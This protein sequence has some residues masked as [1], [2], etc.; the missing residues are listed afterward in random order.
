MK[1]LLNE[2]TKTH[3]PKIITTLSILLVFFIGTFALQN[4]HILTPQINIAGDSTS[5][6]SEEKSNEIITEAEVGDDNKINILITGMGGGSHDAPNLTD[7]I[8]LASIHKLYKTISLLSIPRDLWVGYDETNTGKINEI[9]R[10]EAKKNESPAEGMQALEKKVSEITGESIDYYA[11]IDFNGFT[12]VVDA[13]EGVE[14]TLEKQFVDYSFPDGEGGHRT[15]VLRK[16]TWTLD[17]ETAL[18]YARSRHST[19]DFDRSLRQ[20]QILSAI[21]TKVSQTSF[22][23]SPKKIK[24]FYDIFKEYVFTDVELSDILELSYLAKEIKDYEVIPHNINDSCFYGSNTC[25]AGGFLYVPEREYFDGRSVLL[26]NGSDI[27]DLSDYS[28]I[29]SYM[30]LVFN[31]PLFYSEKIQVNIF[32]ATGI[33]NLA[34]AYTNEAIK[35]G[36]SLPSKNSIGNTKKPYEKS[37]I[38]YNNIDINSNTISTL[39]WFFSGSFKET[40][41]PLYSTDPN[42]KIE[43]ILGDDYQESFNF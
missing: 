12:E 5:L 7:T 31:Y 13:L 42:T 26:I 8:I 41:T 18:N 20:Q 25:A 16:G 15:F 32:N 3:I 9:Y 1:F 34:S 28:G 2:K 22:L 37:I 36:F 11:N 23:G 17:G 33:N 35:Y 10:R 19:S 40:P 38:Y 4:T 14:I 24:A 6:N 43:I 30:D 21:K 29:T 27:T 39:K